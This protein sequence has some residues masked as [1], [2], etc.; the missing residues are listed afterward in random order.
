VIATAVEATISDLTVVIL[1][2]ADA[3]TTT[4]VAGDAAVTMGWG[5]NPF[6]AEAKVF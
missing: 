4:L 6:S 3:D 5:Y 1:T 2:N